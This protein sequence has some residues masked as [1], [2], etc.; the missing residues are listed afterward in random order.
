MASRSLNFF[1]TP[2]EFIPILQEVI[3]T[4]RLFCLAHCWPPHRAWVFRQDELESVV[5]TSGMTEFFQVS[6]LLS[7]RPFEEGD[8]SVYY[9]GV[10]EHSLLLAHAPRQVGHDLLSTWMAACTSYFDST[11]NVVVETPEAVE[12]FSLAARR[13]RK[14]L[15]KP[16]YLAD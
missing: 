15:R 11:H 12:L 2:L 5:M 9:N 7:F 3:R 14:L 6:I 13:F 16:L 8:L 10:C 1:I 4:N